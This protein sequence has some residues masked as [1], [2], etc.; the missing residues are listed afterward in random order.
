MGRLP[1]KI[2]FVCYGNAARSVMAKYFCDAL[3]NGKIIADSVGISP[4]L[5]G[6]LFP[7]YQEEYIRVIVEAMKEAEVD[8]SSHISRHISQADVF[9]FDIVVNM[10]P[11]NIADF[12]K[13]H[14]FK[15]KIIEWAIRDPGNEFIEEVRIA[16]DKIK[17]KVIALIY[18]IS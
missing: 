1:K 9:S 14:D 15:G 7:A 11:I 13:W 12:L 5:M 4:F 16:R 10:A 3:S 18:E 2:L 17:E 8:V 6:R